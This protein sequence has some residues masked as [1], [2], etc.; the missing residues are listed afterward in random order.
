MSFLKVSGI[1]LEEEGNKILQPI[2]FTQRQFQKIAI[3][4]ETG[5]GKSTLLQTIAGLVQP[6][7]GQVYFQ[8]KRVIGPQEQLIPGHPGIAYLSQHFELAPSLRVEQILKYA[9]TFSGLQADNLYELCRIT[10]LL[11]R[12]TNQLSGG[13]RQRIA[14]AR[15]LLGAPL[16]L[17]LDEPFSNLDMGHR[18]ILKSV[19]KDI[20]EELGIS[21]ILISHD[22]LDTLPWAD[23]ILV[24]RSGKIL[25]KGT[26][27]KI[28]KEPVNEYAASLF[29]A[30]N[31][32]SL[33]QVRVFVDIFNPGQK[34][35]N[36]LI[37]PEHFNLTSSDNGVPGIVKKVH[38]FGSYA[39]LEVQVKDFI[40]KVKTLPGQYRIGDVLTVAVA[41]ENI[42][43]V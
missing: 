16:L 21:L 30:Y 6:S 31:L 7:A 20:G 23:K 19:I 14:L 32:L 40:L 3:A 10:H 34:K 35:K 11:K 28:Y 27:A 5:S 12:R 26:P 43:Y 2:S 8:E 36:I 37:R 33:S 39:E 13:E 41:G 4:G 1:S 42:R 29:G 17:L 38:Y 25:Q 18:N 22:P 24:M 15:L 9:N